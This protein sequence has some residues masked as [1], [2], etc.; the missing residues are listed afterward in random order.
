MYAF[1][2]LF[3]YNDDDFPMHVRRHRQLLFPVLSTDRTFTTFQSRMMRALVLQ[4][5]IVY[6]I[7]L[8]TF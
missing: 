8:S 7:T 5:A 1:A 3:H 2:V 4:E 6:V